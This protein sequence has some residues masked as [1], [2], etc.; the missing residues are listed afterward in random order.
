MLFRHSPFKLGGW[1]RLVAL[2]LSAL[3]LTGLIG[4]P[5]AAAA[6]LKLEKLGRPDPVPVTEVKGRPLD[7]PDETAKNRWKPDT[8]TAWPTPGTAVT[9]APAPGAKAAPVKAGSLPVRL[10][11]AEGDTEDA[12]RVQV[13]VLD[14][15]SAEAAGVDG[16]LIAV[17]G[18]G[19]AK[20][21]D[22]L[23]VEIDYSGFAGMYGG[24]WAS[25]LTLRTVPG[26]AL[27]TPGKRGCAPGS[28]VRTANDTERRTLSAE[29]PLPVVSKTTDTPDSTSTSGTSGTTAE[30][31]YP[32]SPAPRT[33]STT[34]ASSDTAL[35]AVDAAPSG[36][37]G[38]FTATPLSP[39]GTWTSGGSSGG[40]SW[41]Y[42]VGTPA[43][44][45]A[46]GPDLGL[47][48]SSQ[49]IDGR[50][51]ATNNQANWIGDGWSMSPGFVERRYTACEGDKKDGNNPSHKV[52]DQCWKKD[53]ATL[54]LNGASS[55]LVKDDATGVW[56]KK[57]DDGTRVQRFTNPSLANGDNDG[58]YWRVTTPDGTRYYFGYNRPNGWAAGKEETNS[59]WT[60]PVFGNHSGEPC[61]ATAF[62]D[63]WCQQ[64]WRWNLD[65][66]IDPHGNA[67][68]YYWAKEGDLYH[69]AIDPTTFKGT[70]T[71]YTRGGYLKR[72]EYG[73]RSGNFYGTP[74]A[75]VDFTVAE[76]CLPTATFDCA[77]EKFTEAN[78]SKWPDT[79]FDQY[80]KAGD[81]CEGK[82]SPSYFTRKR[83]TK[84]ST[85][86]LTGG[87]HKNTDSWT[88][89]HQFPSTGDGTSPP[90]W[91]ASITRAGHTAGDLSMP[92][93]TFRGQQ[94]PNRVEGAV[95]PVPPYN[96]YRVYAVDTESGGTIGVTYSA[97]ECTATTLPTPATNTKRCYPVIWSPPDAP[98]ENYEPYQDWFHSYV[99]TQVLE[100]D[101]TSGAPVK[102]TDYSY[103][104]GLAWGKSDDEFT[105]PEYR[106]YG[107]RRG[108]G[109]VQTRGGD[110]AQGTQTLTENR[111]FRGIAG[112]DVANGEGVTVAD[113]EAF[114]G[115]LREEATYNGVGGA[116]VSATSHTPWRSA[117]TASHARTADGLPT[118][119]AYLTGTAKEQTRNAVTGGTLRRTEETREF[120]SY[121]QVTSVSRTGDTAKSGDE[122]CT[123]TAYARNVSAHIVDKVSETTTVAKP[124]GTTPS[125]PA[126]LVS[127]TRTYYDGSTT[128]GAAPTKGDET[129]R[130]EQNGAGTGYV[131]V[132]TAGYDGYGRQTSATDASGASTTTAYTPAS[133]EAPTQSVTTNALGHTTT[134]VLDPV[135][136]V[137][138]SEIDP[139][140][141]RTD[142]EYDALGRV[143]KVWDQ[144]WSKA[145]YPTLPSAQYSY[146]LSRTDTV[147]VTAK[148]LNHLGEYTTSYTFY[149]GLLRPRATQVPAVGDS[150]G[151]RVVTETLYDTRGLV[152]K[153]YDT[154][155]A[156]GAPSATLVG[157]DD[158]QVPAALKNE[159]DGAG[160]LVAEISL[161]FGDETR[162]TT[163]THGGDRV[164]V[165]PP[166][167][168]VPTTTV[169]DALG[170]KTELR[171]YTDRSL[172][173]HQTTSYA[174]DKHGKVAKVTDPAG[175]VWSWTHDARGRQTVADDPDK[176]ITR[177]YY[178]E[179]DRPQRMV[180][181]RGVELTTVYDELGREKELKQGTTLR[182]SWTY[183]T[184]AKGQVSSNT[185]YTGGAA[186]T[187]TVDSYS[188]R[189]LPTSTTTTVPAAAGTVA[190]TYK[191]TYGYNQYTGAQEWVMHPALGNLPAERVTTN[192]NEEG[193][194]IRTVA[195]RVVLVN[196]V[197]YDVYERVT[198]VELGI[199]GR[200]VYDTRSWDEHTGR[201]NRRTI[202]RDTT[203]QPRVEDTHYTYDLA[204]NVKRI[205]GTSG[206]DTAAVTDTQCFAHDGL[207][208]MTQAWTAKVATDNCATGPSVQTVGGPDAYW[209]SYGYDAI[210]NRVQEVQ[211]TVGTTGTDVT[212]TYTPGDGTQQGPHTLTS[213]S[214]A[215][216]PFDGS[217]ETFG[218]DPIGNTTSRSGG[219]RDQGFTWD[220]E[221]NLTEVTEN[222]KTTSYVYDADGGRILARDADG[223][224][225]AYLPNGNELK[226]TAAGAKEGSRYYTHGDETVA[227]R[228]PAGITF[229]FSDHQGTALIAVASGIGQAVIRRKQLPFGGPRSSSGTNWP[230]NRGFVGGTTDLT[231]TTHL[232]AREYDPALGRFLSVD[233]LMLQGDERQHNGYQYGTNN[234]VTLSDPTGECSSGGGAHVSRC[235]KRPPLVDSKG[236]PTGQHTS[237]HYHN[238]PDSL[239]EEAKRRSVIAQAERAAAERAESIRQAKE[240]QKKAKQ[241]EG[242]WKGVWNKTGGKA[243]SAI[244]ESA[245]GRWVSD[246]WEEIKLGLTVATF[247][248]C[249]VVSVGACIAV[250]AAVATAKFV[251]DGV[252]TGTWDYRAYSKDLAWTAVGGGAAAAFGRAFGGA[253]TWREAYRTNAIS[254]TEVMTKVAPATGMKHA[255]MRP[256]T[257]VDV[258]TT[259]GNMRVNAGFNVGFCGAGSAS[260]GAYSVGSYPGV[261]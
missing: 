37:T 52:G 231:G 114:A 134:K 213:V 40:F 252:K 245:A 58:E 210:G 75:K 43:V 248:A 139:N 80:C 238:R 188:A 166:V 6:Q 23:G 15:A 228:T 76:R 150:S 109:R 2:S 163:T 35:F 7:K 26:C 149:D 202:D 255:V 232:G 117:A 220:A 165:V 156:T 46:L 38:T 182:A 189:Y 200:R 123:T 49:A 223:S 194:P 203:P 82:S 24:D 27:T 167:G 144:G 152:W 9:A 97:P 137:T 175:N 146:G 62:K 125:L 197:N 28:A 57:S 141:Q 138:T 260:L 47:S 100:S 259:Y 171:S 21:R 72:V 8:R 108:Y 157:T 59:T 31:V 145:T 106:T 22:T 254:K 178:D 219:A 29:L 215:G 176:G 216:G 251:G 211:H 56:R 88:L 236:K 84:I 92:P 128:L 73:L 124:C 13:R 244:S 253:K 48:Y 153:A 242:F 14:R 170:R 53:N 67:M 142:A 120:D 198:R 154:Y 45:G 129:R 143:L 32:A 235:G 39:S 17:Q 161:K 93:V 246:H 237:G 173:T 185:R 250:G 190:G 212:R 41:A 164:T 121:G 10:T 168:A 221:G 233:P 74:A 118:V 64:A 12:R 133:G 184:V 42:D 102:R 66:V 207:Q 132:S 87:V 183:D 19:K 140:G 241:E 60:V 71:G 5:V 201:L 25:R 217:T 199:L 186:Y 65:A 68:T 249:V 131:T 258:G 224:A 122:Q 229:L 96:R 192:F 33:I 89:K 20:G 230:G 257:R 195:G 85:S 50:T 261:C 160:R 209:H 136:G 86:V 172:A 55:P 187:T 226:V 208:R 162:R 222:G 206:Q 105:K 104:G 99:V 191:W 174:Y 107:Q 218:Y 112:A 116:L 77:P 4:G 225:T 69:R 119:H 135:R 101:N 61:N 256:Q 95:D 3:L 63:S 90:L 94:L 79:P 151:G 147:V 30:P 83:L 247:V 179:A 81:P 180:D 16:V 193:L 155:Y 78:A 169:T 239:Y 243:V 51:A 70:L 126:D 234:P 240:Q 227:V 113:H 204:G 148:T 205:S 196:N 34:A 127:T 18:Q 54:S 115:M 159:Y 36:P 91:L 158:S 177:T 44:P 98:A 130:D 214:T 110:P 103:L 111:Y 11:A 1:A 181:A